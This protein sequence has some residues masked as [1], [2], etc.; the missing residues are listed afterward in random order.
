MSSNADPLSAVNGTRSARGR[1]KDAEVIESQ[2]NGPYAQDE[3]DQ[4]PPFTLTDSQLSQ[5]LGW[6]SVGVGLLQI[7]APRGV[8][9]AIGVGERPIVMRLC[10]L[11]ELTTGIGLLSERSPAAFAWSRVA[12][13][14]LNLA[15]L[16]GALQ[17]PDSSRARI[18]MAA[19]V[20]AS[21]TAMDIFAGQRLT[22]AAL[23][24]PP[25]TLRSRLSITI[26]ATPERLYSFWRNLDNLPKFMQS[27]QSV[28]AI[29]A[30]QS[31]WV[32]DAPA[33]TLVEWD[34]EIVDDQPNR[35]IAWRTLPDSDVAHHGI[36]SFEAAPSGQGTVV[37]VDLHYRAP[38]GALGMGLAKILSEDPDSHIARVLQRLKQLIETGEVATPVDEPMGWRRMLGRFLWRK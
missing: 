17:S 11:R 10:G 9:R 25:A 21:V 4:P 5:A 24:R 30:Q 14:A 34:S 37:S 20:M 8:G 15:L 18:A 38:G 2:W 36:V 1:A 26:A 31:H 29:S 32:A 7:F 13:D 28:T 22:R 19:T 12:G 35:L 23:S 16:R 33:G 27:V 3:S 6:F